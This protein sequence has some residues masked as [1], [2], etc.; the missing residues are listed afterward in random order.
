[1]TCS[2]R[3]GALSTLVGFTGLILLAEFVDSVTAALTLPS[4]LISANYV[5]LATAEIQFATSSSLVCI[6]L[7][8]P[9]INAYELARKFETRKH[10]I[11][12]GIIGLHGRCISRT[13]AKEQSECQNR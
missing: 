1:M 3:I 4:V 6:I 2:V 8:S 9:N 12:I 10:L 7:S 13:F 5:T 11:E